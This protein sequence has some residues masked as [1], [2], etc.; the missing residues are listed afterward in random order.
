MIV[1]KESFARF[2]YPFL[3]DSRDFEQRARNVEAATYKPQK[4]MWRTQQFPEEELLP[5]V[6]RYLNPPEV[7]DATAH[8]WRLQP[9]ALESPEGVGIERVSIGICASAK[10]GNS[11]STSRMFSFRS[12]VWAWGFLRF[13]RGQSRTKL[14]IGWT[15]SIISGFCTARGVC[16]YG[17]GSEWES[18]MPVR[19]Y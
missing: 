5:H 10:K 8:L 13:G 9:D 3:F 7:T 4:P 19:R 6:A 14:R 12:F 2:V 15:S 11:A 18:T 1:S 17:H 16:R